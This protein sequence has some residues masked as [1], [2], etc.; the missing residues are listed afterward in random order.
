MIP[1][2]EEAAIRA[3]LTPAAAVAVIRAAF[4]AYGEGR[5][6]VPAVINLEIA[7]ARGEFHIKT[8]HIEGTPHIAVKVASGF[9]DNPA[10]LVCQRC[11]TVMEKP[12]P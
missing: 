6:H 11:G 9:F 7:S 2:Y 4:K 3:A 12:T 8:A 5:T 10:N 1:V